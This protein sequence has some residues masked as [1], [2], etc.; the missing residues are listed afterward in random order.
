MDALEGC[1]ISVADLTWKPHFLRGCSC[2]PM[3]FHYQ[4][5]MR[6]A[7]FLT[8]IIGSL[9][10]KPAFLPESSRSFFASFILYIITLR[11]PQRS[12]N[13]VPNPTIS[14]RFYFPEVDPRF[15][16]SKHSTSQQHTKFLSSLSRA[17]KISISEDSIRDNSEDVSMSTSKFSPQDISEM[18]FGDKSVDCGEESTEESNE[19]S[20]EESNEESNKESAEESNEENDGESNEESDEENYEIDCAN[21]E[22]AGNEDSSV[23]RDE[24]KADGNWFRSYEG[25]FEMRMG[26]RV[27]SI[28]G[29]VRRSTL[30]YVIRVRT[31]HQRKV[32][33]RDADINHGVWRHYVEFRRHSRCYEEKLEKIAEVESAVKMELDED[34]A[35]KAGNI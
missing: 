9:H 21:T 7:S 4:V 12:C 6:V 1:G 16:S 35:I 17:P 25:R 31:K 14:L 26:E 15:T 19:E 18:Q 22:E 32:L 3:H 23:D 8:C 29:L 20:T 11:T 34:D 2:Q 24:N 30:E 10:Y 27:R 5:V 28:P 33:F 13:S